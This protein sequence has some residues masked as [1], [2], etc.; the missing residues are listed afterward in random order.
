[1]FISIVKQ[2]KK[3]TFFYFLFLFL[4]S[5]YRLVLAEIIKYDVSLIDQSQVLH[6]TSFILWN[7]GALLYMTLADQLSIFFSVRFMSSA[8]RFLNAQAFHSLLYGNRGM[9]VASANR[10]FSND[11]DMILDH[12]VAVIGSIVYYCLSFVLGIGYLLSIH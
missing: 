1:M 10:I 11:I 4:F 2:N 7:L 9:D 5:A 8:K 12:Y 6:L 3:G